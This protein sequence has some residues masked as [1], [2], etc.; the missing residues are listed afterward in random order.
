MYGQMDKTAREQLLN[1]LRAG[2]HNAGKKQKSEAIHTLMLVGGYARKA[3]IRALNRPLSSLPAPP[4]KRNR[5]PHATV[6][7][8]FEAT[9][10][11]R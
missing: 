6:T 3:A 4:L 8:S 11:L 9:K 5:T 7:F 1:R 10:V 2:Y